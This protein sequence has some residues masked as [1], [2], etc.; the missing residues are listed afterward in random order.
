MV[1]TFWDVNWNNDKNFF[2]YSTK[3]FIFWMYYDDLGYG[4]KN[5]N[6][7]PCH[8]TWHIMKRRKDCTCIL[9]TFFTQQMQWNYEHLTFCFYCKKIYLHVE[10]DFRLCH[11]YLNILIYCSNI[12]LAD[13][14]LWCN[15]T[16]N[17][18]LFSM[19][20]HIIEEKFNIIIVF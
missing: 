3:W 5:S 6:I 8:V 14:V 10:N 4:F 9:L 15:K 16:Q 2:F 7:I 17:V 13:Y 11:K 19:V 20:V 18:A 1:F 12:C